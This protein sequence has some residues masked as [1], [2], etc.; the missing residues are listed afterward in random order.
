MNHGCVFYKLFIRAFP[1]HFKQ[2]SIYAHYPMVIPSENRRIMESIGRADRFDYGRPSPIP[3]RINITSYGAAKYILENQ[4]RYKVTWH[5]G[6]TFL[7]GKGGARFM[8]SGDTPDH[9]GQRKC[10]HAQLYKDEWRAH[11]KQFYAQITEQL[12]RDNSCRVA[13]R[14]QVDVIRD[15]GN[16]SHVHFAA[17][18]FNLPLKT[19]ENPKG[20]YTEH[21]L[22]MV[23]ALIFVTIFFDIDPVKSFPLRQ[24]TKTV[25][26]QLGKLIETN[27]KI[28]RRFGVRGLFSGSARR[29]DPLAMYGV[30]MVQGLAKSGLSNY[31]IAWSQI[32]PTAGAMVPNQAEVVSHGWVGEVTTK[33]IN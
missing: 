8:L 30:H 32:L 14:R 10:M 11:I 17:R 33:Q 19:M 20:I 22:Y 12:L 26:D 29:D 15:V 24:A 1:N 5:E 3:P 13:G 18:V 25:C 21:E 31:D 7:M 6:L 9:A 28:T 23:L 2:N 4:D 16:I 27:V